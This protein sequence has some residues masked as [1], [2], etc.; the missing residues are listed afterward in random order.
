MSKE[1]NKIRITDLLLGAL[2]FTFILSFAVVFVLNFRPLYYWNVKNSNLAKTTGFSEALIL[3]NYN[4]LIDYNSIFSSQKLIFIGL[5]MSSGAELHFAEVKRIFSFLQLLCIF[6]FLGSSVFG[7]MKIKKKNPMFLLF[8]FFISFF[9]PLVFGI[10]VLLNWNSLFTT[11]HKL[12]FK[13]DFWIFDPRTDPIINIL[14]D[15][16]FKRCGIC[17]IVIIFILGLLCL[18]SYLFTKK[19]WNTSSKEN[20]ICNSSKIEYEKEKL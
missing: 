13:N 20:K 3:Q 16:F 12:F 2:L 18:I 15:A 17:I 9:V 14:P 7:F 6:S 1:K 4:I 19:Y 5:P 10:L 11:F 8:T